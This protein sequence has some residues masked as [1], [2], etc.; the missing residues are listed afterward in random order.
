MTYIAMSVTEFAYV[1]ATVALF[2][3]LVERLTR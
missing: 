1:V 3:A 2:V